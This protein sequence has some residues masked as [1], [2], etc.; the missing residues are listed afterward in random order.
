MND[1]ILDFTLY[2]ASVANGTIKQE[3]IKLALLEVSK[4]CDLFPLDKFNFLKTLIRACEDALETID[5]DVKEQ[6][7]VLLEKLEPEK[8]TEH[9]GGTLSYN[10]F[11]DIVKITFKHDEFVDDYRHYQDEECVLYRKYVKER[12]TA[13]KDASVA[14]SKMKNQAEV[15]EKNHPEWKPKPE[16]ITVS[17]TAKEKTQSIQ[18][19]RSLE[20]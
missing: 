6:V 8:R 20:A 14:S 7:A 4:N 1:N 9:G 17:I 13:R 5:P 12:N 3:E 15:Y 18:R 10:G 19:S 2:P 11:D 16:N